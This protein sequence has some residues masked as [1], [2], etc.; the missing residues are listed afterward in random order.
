MARTASPLTVLGAMH[1]ELKK[2][3]ENQMKIVARAETALGKAEKDLSDFESSIAS[4]IGSKAPAIP[5]KAQEKKKKRGG[6]KRRGITVTAALLS[7]LAD[8]NGMSVSEAVA[9]ANEKHR[10]GI[11]RNT[12]ST[13]LSLLKKEGKVVNDKDGWKVAKEGDSA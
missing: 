3:V 13:T 11:Q 5:A 4:L 10:V 6:G 7:A 1:R 9:A 12:A 8:G 2:A